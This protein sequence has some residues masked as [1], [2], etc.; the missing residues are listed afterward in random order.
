MVL[1][2]VQYSALPAALDRRLIPSSLAGLMYYCPVNVM[3]R[4]AFGLPLK[5]PILHPT[6]SSLHLSTAF[7]LFY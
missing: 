6:R 3:T 1:I 4:V 5:S 2:G 7:Y